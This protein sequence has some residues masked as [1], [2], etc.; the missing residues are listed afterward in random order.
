MYRITYRTIKAQERGSADNVKFCCGRHNQRG[1]GAAASLPYHGAAAP[2]SLPKHGQQQQLSLC[3]TIRERRTDRRVG[4]VDQLDQRRFV[5]VVTGRHADVTHEPPIPPEQ[6]MW[7][8]QNG[9]VEEANIHVGLI[10]RH[11]P[12]R[13]PADAGRRL[14]IMQHLAHIVARGAEDLEPVRSDRSQGTGMTG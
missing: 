13:G 14:S 12:K 4:G 2:P 3:G 9:T 11:I 6:P 7:I 8:G 5:Q 10:E 1:G